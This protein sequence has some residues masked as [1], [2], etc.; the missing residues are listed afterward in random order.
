MDAPEDPQHVSGCNG[1]TLSG[2]RRSSLDALKERDTVAMGKPKDVYRSPDG[3]A[4]V[5]SWCEARLTTFK[6]PYERLSIET[7]VG[8]TQ[9]VAT[10]NGDRTVVLL[11]GTN[12]ATATWLDV[13]SELAARYRV[14]A[15][16]IPGQPGL[17]ASTRPS[18][19]SAY[20]RWV[21]EVLEQLGPQAPILL[22][23]SLGA[24]IA[25]SAA[26]AVSIGGLVLI[27]P[28]GIIRLR[29]TP[30]MLF[31][32]M[33]WLARR[34]EASSAALL[35]MMTTRESP[36]ENLVEWM[37]LVG[38]HVRTSLAP[39]PLPASALGRVNVPCAIRSGSH[40][41]FLPARRLAAAVSTS[42]TGSLFEVVH[43]AGHLLPHERPDAV[44]AAV[45]TIAG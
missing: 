36:P 18:H 19:R 30:R 31:R 34:D 26:A 11:P 38:K 25:L 21:E 4:S 33:A 15:L 13:I 22:G 8:S 44:V 29:V 12:F 1:M 9:G 23:H 37:T 7:S 28:A 24:H 14:V 41:V 27:S 6:L 16:D 17:S 20:V 45:Q 39:S 2:P 42:L 5:R 40:D 32:S 35:R 3:R 43:G 10:G